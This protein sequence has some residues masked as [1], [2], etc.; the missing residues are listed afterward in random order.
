[1]NLKELKLSFQRKKNERIT[2]ELI[3]PYKKRINLTWEKRLELI[4]GEEKWRLKHQKF[5]SIYALPGTRVICHS[6]RNSYP[7]F[8]EGNDIFLEEKQEYTVK[9][10]FPFDCFTLVELEEMPGIY[11]NSLCFKMLSD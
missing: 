11:F 2:E 3:K 6:L 1:M 8:I 9:E 5:L 10:T 7:P 4:A